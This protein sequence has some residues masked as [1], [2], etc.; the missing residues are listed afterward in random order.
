MF[1]GVS[2]IGLAACAAT[3]PG[4]GSP[5]SPPELANTSW[6]GVVEG[7]ADARQLPRLTFSTT[8]A[9]KDAGGRVQGFTGCNML[10]GAYKVEGG[11]V[12][13]GPMI[14]TKRF[15]VG[16]EMEYERRLLA[17]MGEDSRVTREGDRLVIASGKGRFEFTPAK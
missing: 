5:P 8:P 1:G 2:C 15:C 10:S 17:A 9:E 7:T 16:P 3:G 13:L 11:V 4:G 6:V 14:T 12:K